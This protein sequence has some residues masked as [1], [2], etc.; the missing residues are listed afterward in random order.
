MWSSDARV[1]YRLHKGCSGAAKVS[2]GENPLPIHQQYFR[3]V[4]I[5]DFH[6]GTPRCKGEELL[7]FL[8]T[9]RA[10]YLYLVG[11]IIDGWNIGPAWCWT[12]AQTALVEEIW[13]WRREGTR[14]TYL[15]GNHDECNADL[16]RTLFGDVQ[17]TEQLVHQTAE[18]R[19]MLVIHGHQFDGSLNAATWVS[20]VGSV[21]YTS[22]LR[23]NLWYNRDRQRL[24]AVRAM[25]RR[26]K[27]TVHYLVDFTD[28]RVAESARRNRVDGVICGHTHR[29]AKRMIGSILYVNDGD[30]VQSRTA[31]VEDTSGELRLLGGSPATDPV[32]R[33]PMVLIP[34]T[35]T[36]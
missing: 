35:G 20:K 4:W 25:R 22:A 27:D 6:L 15:P 31:L 33:T 23:V 12:P 5:S 11:D 13:R 8:R 29:P 10:E 16:V 9:H 34:E 7:Q 21:A 17:C 26:I 32:A 14:I 3:S 2:P 30:W 36:I 1:E 19:R 18:G 24:R 28:R